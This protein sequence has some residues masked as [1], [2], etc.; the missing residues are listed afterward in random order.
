MATI[1]QAT[2]TPTKLELLTTWL[3][4]R[5]WYPGEYVKDLQRVGA[6]RFDDPAGEVGLEMIVVR[7]EDGPLVH[8]PLTYRGAALEDAEQHLIGTMEHSVLGTRWVYDAVADPVYLSVL[9]ATIRTG[10]EQA[11]ELVETQDGPQRREPN[12]RVRGSGQDRT[13]APVGPPVRLEEGDPA[14]VVTEEVRLELRRVLSS[15]PAD[16]VLYL[17]GTWEGN[18]SPTV[19]AELH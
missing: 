6:C 17:S 16:G 1:H 14:V 8:V 4:S 7:A 5:H 19:L 9:T 12:M 15:E 13:S 10:G 18:S 2:L 11:E 3:S